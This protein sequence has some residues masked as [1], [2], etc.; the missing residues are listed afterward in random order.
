MS[1]ENTSRS[2]IRLPGAQED[3]AL[4]VAAAGKPMVLLLSAGRPIELQ[5]I[6]K[7]MDA[8]LAI[9]Q[10]GT[11]GGPAIA[12][13]LVGRRSPSGRLSVTF[14]RTTGQIPIYHNMRPRA[15]LGDMGT[16]KD[17]STTPLYEFGHGLS[18][19]TFDYGPIVLS[20]DRVAPGKTLAAEVT[21]RNTGKMAAAETVFWFIRQ[22]A[23][24][25]TR[26]FKDLKHF[27][28]AD[29]PAGGSRV[30]RFDIDP[31][32]DLSYPDADGRRILDRGEIILLAGPHQAR[33]TVGP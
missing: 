28:K 20:S 25:I 5:R 16:Y 32:R 15:R 14:P 30:F 26:P 18:Y 11:R 17:I 13:I 12:D 2:S 8:I 6:E 4:E 7:K 31:D 23:A 9:W 22:P 29:I 19:T 33:F 1:G 27:E 10:S 21:V 3:L 24:S